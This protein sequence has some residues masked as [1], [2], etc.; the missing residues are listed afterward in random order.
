MK[1]FT[2]ITMAIVALLVLSC[3][4][5]NEIVLMQG[6]YSFSS[7]SAS[8]ADLPTSRVHLENDGKVVW[9]VNDNIGI[10]SD[11]Q[12]DPVMFTCASIN[13]SK[14]SFTSSNEVSGNSFLAFFPYEGSEVEGNT[15]TYT[16]SSNT[17]YVANTYFRQ[18]P[19]IAKSTT[20]DFAFKHTCGII[21]FSITG[22]QQ[23]SSLVL[24]G[25][26][27]EIIAG[28]GS[29]NLNVETPILSIPT[30]AQDASKTITMS[31]NDLQLSATSTDFYFIIPETEFTQGL[32]LTINYLNIDSSITSIK[33]TTSK[34]VNISRSVMKSFSIFDTDALLQEETGEKMYEALMAFYNATGGN[35]WTNNTNWGD[36]TKDYNE[37]YGVSTVYDGSIVKLLLSN[38]NLTGAI[39]N[40]LDNLTLLQY[41]SIGDN[42]ITALNVSKNYN[43][44]KL[45]CE[46]NSIASLDLRKNSKLTDLTCYGN[47]I[48]ELLIESENLKSLV[49]NNNNIQN[50]D[51]SK[52]KNLET[53]WLDY[54]KISQ[55]DLE[56]NTEL[57]QIRLCGNPLLSLNLSKN[58]KVEELALDHKIQFSTLD[59]SNMNS[60]KELYVSTSPLET[61]YIPA[62][63]VFYYDSPSPDKFK[64]KE[65][66]TLYT[67]SDMSKD[68][69][70]EILQTATE[71]NGID[72]IF[73]GEGFVD[74]QLEDGTYREYMNM[75]KDA[76][77]E[78]EPYKEFKKLFNVYSVNL[79]SK[80]IGK[81]TNTEDTALSL[82]D[83]GSIGCNDYDKIYK[84]VKNAISEERVDNAIVCIILNS[85]KANGNAH[86]FEENTIE[87]DYGNGAGIAFI[88]ICKYD[89]QF[90]H[91]LHHECGHS[92]A[93]LGDEYYFYNG[94]TISTEEITKYKSKEEYG[95]WK[96]I[97]FTDNKQAIKWSKFISDDRYKNEVGV[98][99][100]GGED[101][102]YGIYCPTPMEYSIMG[103]GQSI[104]N[105]PSREA[106]YYRIHKLAY[107][108]DWEYD[109]DDFVEYDAKNRTVSTM[110][111]SVDTN[112]RMTREH[113]AP[114]IIKGPWK[115]A[116]K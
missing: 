75:A 89:F 26:N 88:R 39:N 101:Y 76:F 110:T 40:E 61:I 49:C 68:G 11:T 112:N 65:G 6:E 73:M 59:I 100:G 31:T 14:A 21:R 38:N 104:F 60:L 115:D 114:V 92:F 97:D 78:V 57:S 30:N 24:Q 44:E 84:Y 15:M 51:I 43:L 37:W 7:V 93:K 45:Y 54:N 18:S 107:G 113:N 17:Q 111:R 35:N 28:T 83:F 52:C 91:L 53:I 29:I 3:T 71:G 105:A 79:V 77:F 32:T 46:N 106:I 67:S 48:T 23:I 98:Y 103:D 102:Q 81:M 20:N 74:K 90:M 69:T 50:L 9:D 13:D 70:V 33:K 12:T 94:K 4:N 55:I 25:N 58:S 82:I 47:S 116:I 22:T 27:D 109:F 16:L 19:M 2:I 95:W 64:Y 62:N 85:Y 42:K 108:K 36:K 80:N 66:A 56:A 99:E 5:D 1:K 10:F 41:L 72:L 86:L 87:G 8:M 96:N 34:S 63:H